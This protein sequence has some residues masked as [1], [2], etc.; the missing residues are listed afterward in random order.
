MKKKEKIILEK[1][2][3]WSTSSVCKKFLFT[4]EELQIIYKE[5][6]RLNKI[7]ERYKKTSYKQ[8]K[9]IE[10]IKDMI[11]EKFYDL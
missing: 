1:F 7:I 4:K 9:Q 5:Y 8:K 3:R 11:G 10:Y 2:E 6:V